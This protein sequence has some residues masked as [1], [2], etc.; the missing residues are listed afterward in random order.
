MP[1]K[2]FVK[3]RLF[4][5]KTSERKSAVSVGGRSERNVEFKD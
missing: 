4:K 2:D 5:I 3:T 1:K